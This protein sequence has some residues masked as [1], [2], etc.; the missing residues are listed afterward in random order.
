MTIQIRV[1][2]LKMDA[3]QNFNY[4]EINEFC[5]QNKIINMQT[6]FFMFQDEPIWSILITCKEK[7][8]I[9]ERQ[10]QN[11]EKQE[12]QKDKRNPYYQ[13]AMEHRENYDALR[14]WRNQ[15]AISIG[16]PPYAIATNEMLADIVT[17]MPTSK[18][19]LKTINGIGK[20]FVDS[21]GDSILVFLADVTKHSSTNTSTESISVSHQQPESLPDCNHTHDCN[22]TNTNKEVE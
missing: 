1:F 4:D 17:K 14:S 13:L 5:R 9:L 7:T 16:K 21:F 15:L 3:E 20:G 22:S 11:P 18:K 6:Q 8:S 2:S 19:Q 10:N 12:L